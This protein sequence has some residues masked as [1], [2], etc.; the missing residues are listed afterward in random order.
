MLHH[1]VKIGR[2]VIA[3]HK[4]HSLINIAGLAMGMAVAILTGLWARDEYRMDRFHADSANLYRVMTR[5]YPGNGQ[6]EAHAHT[7]G[8]LYEELR[9]KLPEITQTCVISWETRTTIRVGSQTAMEAGRFASADFFRLFSFPLLQ[10]TAS[11]ALSTPTGIA[12][13]ETLARKYFRTPEAA[14][15]QSMRVD[16]R[17]VFQVTAVFAD[18]PAYSSLKFDYVLPWVDFLA[19][20]P[21]LRDWKNAE[22]FTYVRLHG[23]SRRAGLEAKLTR[24][25]DGYRLPLK[26]ELFLQRYD[27]AYLYSNFT[28]GQPDGGRI[29]YVRLFGLV[30]GFV[31]L[32]ACINFANLTTARSAQR[33]KEVS[34]R[35]VMGAGRASLAGQFMGEAVLLTIFAL[36]IAL[37]LS[38][39]ILPAFNELS[40]KQI[41]L[42]PLELPVVL[43]LLTLTGLTGGLAG[44]YPAFFLSSLTPVEA[45]TTR[46]RLSPKTVLF[47]QSLVVVQFGLSMLLL[48][49]TL[50]VYRQLQF[51]QTKHLGYQR[52]QLLYIPMEGALAAQY[53]VFKQ[54]LLRNPSWGVASVTRMGQTPT[55][56]TNST[57]EVSWP[58]KDQQEQVHFMQVP[59]GYDFL[60]TLDIQ[61]VAG[62][63]LSS[64][65]ADSTSY[66]INETAARR[67]GIQQDPL[68]RPVT[69]LGRSG[70]VVGVVRDFHL[71]SLHEPI[72]PLLVHLDE[73]NAYWGNVVLRLRAGQER[74]A[75]VRLE[76]LHQQLNPDVPF[77]YQ[78]ADQAYD[79]LYRSE[80]VVGQLAAYFAFLAIFISCLGL[81]SLAS[82]SAEQRRKEIGIRK[83]LGASVAGIVARLVGDLLRPVLLAFVVALPLS[84]W[85]MHHWLQ[86]FAYR[87]EIR[88]WWF[89]GVG[90]GA[91]LVT[92]LTVSYQAVKAARVNPVKSL[93]TE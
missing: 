51:T 2:R 23:D 27:Q 44:A 66:V 68:G 5:V 76:A 85:A 89:V 11:A 30:A 59:V 41:R 64:A 42:Y 55:A 93:R 28:N 70:H 62:R 54:Q 52:A 43:G 57:L 88:W 84:W 21:W 15:G 90:G 78:F 60:E 22:P 86:Q 19:L 63:G 46:Q 67:M 39:L 37:L 82:F 36:L 53:S 32:I 31:L 65:F 87:T 80:R 17:K 9:A 3:R 38:A 74:V 35:K 49:G 12:I 7:Q 47:R 33:G 83:A 71:K 16:N 56:M 91:L 69:F 81:L 79:A 4:T 10:G 72:P 24:F 34:V 45:L 73:K 75:L 6:V 40:G 14:M 20:N 48:M 61:L 26:N 8:L 18:P 58:G 77:S 50:I 1:Y 25:L 92:V 13:S 29:E